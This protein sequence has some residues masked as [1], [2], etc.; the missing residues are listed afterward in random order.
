MPR[1]VDSQ[2]TAAPASTWKLAVERLL[3]QGRPVTGPNLR[4]TLESFRQVDVECFA[5]ITYSAT[6][7]PPPIRRARLRLAASGHLEATGQSSLSLQPGWLG[8]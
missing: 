5:A 3:D 4:A 1:L 7:Y 2:S 8:W 6:D